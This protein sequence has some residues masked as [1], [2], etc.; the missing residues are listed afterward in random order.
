MKPITTKLLLL[1]AGFMFFGAG[2]STLVEL[3]LPLS[4]DSQIMI[5]ATIKL[6]VSVILSTWA[7]ALSRTK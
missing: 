2:V 7:L 3:A 5:S 4:S 6:L 1:C